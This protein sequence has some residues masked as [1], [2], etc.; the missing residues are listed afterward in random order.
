MEIKKTMVTNLSNY[1]AARQYLEAFVQS[2]TF[3]NT[4]QLALQ[5]AKALMASL[6]DPQ[7]RLSVIHLAGTSGKGSTATILAALLH[8][9]GLKVGLGLSPHVRHLLERV[10]INGAPIAENDFCHVLSEMIP[11]INLIQE[12]EWGAPSFFEILIALSYKLFDQLAVNVVVME[13]GLG[14]RYDATNTVTCADKIALFTEIGYDHVEVLGNTLAKI[15]YQKAGIIQPHNR[16]LTFLQAPEAQ[17]V[18]AAESAAQDAQLTIFDSATAIHNLQLYPTEVIFDL[19]LPY[20]PHLHALCLSLAGAHQAQNAGLAIA[21]AHLFLT[22][23]ER[24]LNE[25]AIRHALAH[26]TLPGRM[27]QRSWRGTRF[28][29]DGAHNA[30]KMHA[31]CNALAALYPNQR[32]IFVVALKQGKD[33]SAI[34]AQILP[35]AKRI[36]LTRF[37]NQDQGMP[38]HATDPAALLMLIKS[39][40]NIPVEVVPSVAEALALAVD[41]STS[42]PATPIVVTGSLYLLAQVYTVIE[43]E[44][45]HAPL[46]RPSYAH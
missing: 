5:R 23:S 32:F 29:I 35:I 39:A 31:L 28:I 11:A 26:V 46:T 2:S 34:F 36:I 8:A 7:N 24:T 22:A 3:G 10:Q 9:H 20:G 17:A 18:I 42:E 1:T 4:P 45:Q 37:D 15:A 44:N 21:A 38:V 14:G 40:S 33:H 27:D 25:T 12:S 19:S 13:T 43:G 30:Q 41:L 16:V 6:G